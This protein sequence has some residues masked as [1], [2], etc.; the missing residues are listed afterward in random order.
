MPTPP[1]PLARLRITMIE[2]SHD[3]PLGLK[4]ERIG[5]AVAALHCVSALLPL[6]ESLNANISEAAQL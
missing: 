6:E 2:P 4:S 5:R 3:Q 1:N